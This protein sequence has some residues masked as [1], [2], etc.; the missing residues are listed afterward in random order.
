M[1]ETRGDRGRD[2]NT[3]SHQYLLQSIPLVPCNTILSNILDTEVYLTYCPINFVAF[4][5]QDSAICTKQLCF[6]YVLV[7]GHSILLFIAFD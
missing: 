1:R 4:S 2:E 5:L 3:S 6:F 7:V